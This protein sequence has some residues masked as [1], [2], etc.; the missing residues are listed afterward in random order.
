MKTDTICSGY[1]TIT[2]PHHKYRHSLLLLLMLPFLMLLPSCSNSGAKPADPDVMVS[3]RTIEKDGE[4]AIA[5]SKGALNREFLFQ[6]NRVILDETANFQGLKSRIVTFQRKGSRLFML[7]SPKGHTVTPDS[8]FAL[9]LAEFPILKDEDGWITFD[10]NAGMSKIFITEELMYASDYESE[11]YQPSFKTAK[12]RQSFLKR[13]DVRHLNRL[14]I[15]QAAQI[16]DKDDRIIHAEVHYYISPYRPDPDFEPTLSPGFSHAGYFEVMPQLQPGGETEIFA[17]KWNINKGP[18]TYSMSANTPEEFR[19]AVRNGVLYWNA[20]LGQEIFAVDVA[21]EDASAPDMDRNIIQWVENDKA[22][23]AYAD[24][25]ADP[26]TGE[27]LHSQIFMPNAWNIVSRKAAWR[28][29]YQ[30]RKT[31]H[32]HHS[33]DILLAN[34]HKPRICA[35]KSEDLVLKGMGQLLTSDATDDVFLRAAQAYVQAVVTHEVGHTMG[36]RHNF[37]GNMQADWKGHNRKERYQAFL[38]NRTYLPG[39]PTTSIMDYSEPPEF[40]MSAWRFNVENLALPHDISAMRYLYLNEPMDKSL[41]FCTDSD[42]DSM[43]DCHR[44]AHGKSPIAYGSSELYQRLQ[45]ENIAREL[46]LRMVLKILDGTPIDKLYV[47][48]QNLASS[49]LPFKQRYLEPF[50]EQAFYARALK[51]RYPDPRSV[52]PTQ[53]RRDTLPL[54]EKDLDDW[55]ENNPYGFKSIED[56]FMVIDPAWEVE[57]KN[58]FNKILDDPLFYTIETYEGGTR[59]LSEAERQTLKNIGKNYFEEL[60]NALVS[61]DVA[62]LSG[63]PAIDIVENKAGEGLLAAFEKTSRTYLMQDTGT[64]LNFPVGGKDLSLPVFRYD[65][66]V[67]GEAMSLL[68]DRAVP[69]ALWW[70]K[71]ESRDIYLNMMDVLDDAVAPTSAEFLDSLLYDEFLDSTKPAFQWYLENCNL[72]GCRH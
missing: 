41:Y 32:Q 25:Q 30:N 13:T 9:I 44:F 68:S 42:A 64:F 8:S 62:M 24:M 33:A 57:W 66:Q 69:S 60:V 2:G 63:M 17:M 50:T 70:G 6:G 14:S 43:A 56:M 49:I 11:N 71:R 72:A 10:F 19:E 67:R 23:S 48:P 20:T 46:Y 40:T 58:E 55:L 15:Q 35:I 16:E 26:R 65:W 3:L 59:Q 31:A 29:V 5:I 39:I 51:S 38:E 47:D 4:A 22:A 45:P 54:V 52:S 28:F 53:K 36:L 7:E 27:I 21:P 61:E 37:A 34:F 12:V 1:R 18:I